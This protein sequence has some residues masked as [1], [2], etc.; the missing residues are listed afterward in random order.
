MRLSLPVLFFSLCGYGKKPP[1]HFKGL[2]SWGRVV[3]DEIF[4]CY[5][6]LSVI[7]R[8]D[9]MQAEKLTIVFRLFCCWGMKN[10]FC[11][12][13]YAMLKKASTPTKSCFFTTGTP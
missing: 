7:N 8:T 5:E 1:H 11:D 4:Y 9:K 2:F 3:R 6:F 10:M 13:P 12:T